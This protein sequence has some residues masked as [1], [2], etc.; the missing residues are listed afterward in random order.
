[1]RYSTPLIILIVLVSTNVTSPANADVVVNGQTGPGA[2]YRLVRPDNWN[3]RLFLYAHGYVSTDEPV[4]LPAEGQQ[5]AEL[6]ASQGF[7]VAYSSFSENG[8]AVKDG[9]RRTW[10]LK[11]LFTSK[12]GKPT[13]VYVA[14][15][16]MG[17]LIAI[18]LAERYPSAFIGVL[19]ACS[20]AGGTRAQYDYFANVRAIFDV[21][22]PGVLP[23]NAGDVSE[24]VDTT[25]Q[26]VVPAL[27]AMTGDP[28]GAGLL[29]SVEQTPAPY[30]TPEELAQSIVTALASHA[31]SFREFLPDLHYQP[32]FD[33]TSTVY[34]GA[35]PPGVIPFLNASISRFSASPSAL[36]Y[37]SK[38]YEPTG[39][40]DVPMLML[41]NANDPVVPG[42]HQAIYDQLATNAGSGDLL[43]QRTVD[44]YGHCL[45]TPNE[46]ASAIFDL[47][48]WV[49][50]GV[51]PT[52]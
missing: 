27:A 2:L 7:G 47:I 46:L 38:H 23:G 20:V 40:I 49:E 16:S 39:R 35:L 50:F 10:Q 28:A 33:N 8:W 6:L 19:P 1:M 5:L 51:M 48:A 13:G 29:A 11:N 22:Y 9:A 26:I 31:A 41:S 30:T 45:F 44:R 18:E 32:Y 17:G 25:L 15:A 4:A 52:K 12:F 34:S 21:F 37:M 43:V 36:N 24:S 3:G 14:G 42:F